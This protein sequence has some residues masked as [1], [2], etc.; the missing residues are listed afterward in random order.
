MPGAQAT[1]DSGKTGA[2]FG[3]GT[4]ISTLSDHS[5]SAQPQLIA[6]TG[7]RGHGEPAWTLPSGSMQSRAGGGNSRGAKMKAYLRV[8]I[9]L[10]QPESSLKLAGGANRDPEGSCCFGSLQASPSSRFA[11]RPS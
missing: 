1:N 4:K 10:A 2:G 11:C 7:R 6:E 3:E 5:P 9:A 8:H